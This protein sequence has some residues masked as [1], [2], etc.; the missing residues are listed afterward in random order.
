MKLTKS[1]TGGS[2][3]TTL[4]GKASCRKDTESRSGEVRWGIQ[5]PHTAPVHEDPSITRRSGQGRED[6]SGVVNGGP[7]SKGTSN[8]ATRRLAQVREETEL[9]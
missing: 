6:R 2:E 5:K 1:H 9:E 8:K 4:S 7:R 3:G